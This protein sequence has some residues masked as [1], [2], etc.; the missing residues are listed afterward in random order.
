MLG[1][2]AE[3]FSV[4]LKYT[5]TFLFTPFL[6]LLSSHKRIKLR[7]ILGKSS[8]AEERLRFLSSKIPSPQYFLV[9]DG[10][11]KLQKSEATLG[12]LTQRYRVYCVGVLSCIRTSVLT[13]W[14]SWLR[15]FISMTSFY[16]PFCICW[17]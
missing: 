9:G 8:W 16:L 11:T 1:Y 5:K 2:R 7:S 12:I 15:I 4:N 17:K 13:L 6:I 3:S 14:K 10:Q